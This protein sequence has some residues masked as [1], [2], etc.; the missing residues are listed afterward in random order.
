MVWKSFTVMCMDF[1]P[2]QLKQIIVRDK[3]IVIPHSLRKEIRQKLHER[4]LG[5]EKCKRRSRDSVY[6]H[7]INKDMK[8]NVK[9]ERST[10][11]SRAF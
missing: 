10:R 9:H 7:G 8:I 6:W 5:I 3:R 2:S 11:A 4:H 1:A